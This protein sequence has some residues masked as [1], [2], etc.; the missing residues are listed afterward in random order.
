MAEGSKHIL[1]LCGGPCVG[2]SALIKQ[3]AS[4]VD[5]LDIGGFYTEPEYD[6][7]QRVGFKVKT[8]DGAE[9]LAAHINTQSNERVGKFGVDSTALDSIMQHAM[10]VEPAIFLIDELGKLECKSAY[11][12][13]R[14]EALLEA[15]VV[16]V[17]TAPLK[18]TSLLEKYQNHPNVLKIR[19][20]ETNAEQVLHSAQRWL[21]LQFSE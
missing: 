9:V 10:N 7:R 15:N 19:I 4:Q 13:Q 21:S 20:N 8:F 17:V 3:L 2:K 18:G 6:A 12:R 11:F 14:M 5:K 16:M 1:L